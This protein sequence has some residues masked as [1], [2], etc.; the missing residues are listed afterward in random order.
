MH[1]STDYK[2]GYAMLDKLVDLRLNNKYP[3][4]RPD[5]IIPQN[6][7]PPEIRNN[8]RLLACFYFYICIYMRGGIES[9]QAFNAMI[10][11]W[12]VHP[13]LFDPLWAQMLDP[14]VVQPI[15]KKFVGWDSKAASINWVTN[16]RLL[17]KNWNADPLNLLKKLRAYD[18]ALR[19]IRNKRTKRDL[20]EAGVGNEGFRGFQPKMVSM[21]IY[22]YDWEG[23]LER[24]FLYPSPADFHN[25]R[26]AIANGALIVKLEPGESLKSNEKLS[27]PWRR[28]VMDYLKDRKADPLIVADALWLYSLVLCGNSPMTVSKEL[29]PRIRKI[30]RKEKATGKKVLVQEEKVVALFEH[31]NVKEEWSSTEW[32]AGKSARLKQTCLAC[33]LATTCAYAI[34]SRPYYRKGKL[35]L[36]PRPRVERHYNNKVLPPPSRK[37]TLIDPEVIRL[38][39]GLEHPA[40]A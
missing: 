28:L 21:L 8:K 22:F 18:E 38:I 7:I 29:K 11:M 25:F 2:A 5:A 14:K 17:V 1:V 4:N 31:S 40:P 3:F 35:I 15:L 9:L 33:V 10:R 36:N 19:R 30:Y 16:S 6:I 12:R 23:W 32:A 24:R 34:P 39:P 26:L 20:R 37:E 27:A 13:E